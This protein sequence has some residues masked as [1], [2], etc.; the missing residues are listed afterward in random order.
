MLR[1]LGGVFGLERGHLRFESFKLEGKG[2]RKGKNRRKGRK[3][4]KGVPRGEEEDV[5]GSQEGQ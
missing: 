4:R 2:R 3:G 1:E 5:R